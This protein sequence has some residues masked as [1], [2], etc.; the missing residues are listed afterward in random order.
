MSEIQLVNSSY[1]TVPAAGS[2]MTP[3]QI[4][5]EL[6]A[7]IGE[8]NYYADPNHFPSPYSDIVGYEAALAKVNGIMG[9]ITALMTPANALTIENQCKT[10]GWSGSIPSYRQ[11]VKDLST[12]PQNF[13]TSNYGGQEAT[14]RFMIEAMS[15]ISYYMTHKN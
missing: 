11:L 2:G 6:N 14:I 1:Y 5:A 8:L 10:N 13:L 9:Q 12:W 15:N 3:A 4:V 7:L